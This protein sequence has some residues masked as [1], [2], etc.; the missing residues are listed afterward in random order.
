[1]RL[2]LPAQ[3]FTLRR[4]Q[5]LTRAARLGHAVGVLPEG[6][7]DLPT[8]IVQVAAAVRGMPLKALLG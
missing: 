6:Q 3:Q 4:Q 7:F 5:L 8:A 1:M 2:G